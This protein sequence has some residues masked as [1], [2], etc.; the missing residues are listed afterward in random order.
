MSVYRRHL[1]VCTNRRP[2]GHPRGSCAEK[3][4]EALRDALKDA[5]KKRG[6]GKQMRVNAAGCLDFCEHGCTMV[7]YPEGIWY[8]GVKPEDVDEII[9]ETMVN[10]RVIERLVPPFARPKPPSSGT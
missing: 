9:D 6:M 10:G 2:E 8:G 4:S 5:L 1:F 7:V 3:G